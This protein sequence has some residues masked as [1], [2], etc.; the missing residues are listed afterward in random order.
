[1]GELTDKAIAILL[2]SLRIA[3]TLGFSPPFTLVRVPAL[4]RVFLAI[5]LAGWLVAARPGENWQADY[6][7]NGLFLTAIGELLL[8]IALSLS[9]QLAF[10]ALFTAGRTI[11]V[12]A[13]FG[14]AMLIDPTTRTQLPLVGTLFAYAAGAI[15]FAT[16][17]PTDL[18]AI[19]SESLDQVPL[20]SAALGGDIT[21]LSSYISAV[22]VMAFGLG[23]LVTLVL[24]LSDLAIAFM[25][26]TLPQM[27][28]ML[29]GFQ[30]KAMVML[31]VL[32]IALAL[33]G[34]LFLRMLRYALETA[35][36]LI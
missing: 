21:V 16:E 13:G 22:F 8:G 25:S 3:P 12:Q 15:F 7:T 33:S 11:D 20:G 4:V 34:S 28:V 29:M 5:G 19:W 18:L 26:R 10:A 6:R 1:M 14:M 35:P 36:R 31:A 2:I 30:V 23:G 9:L 27:N 32:P 17:G 24:F